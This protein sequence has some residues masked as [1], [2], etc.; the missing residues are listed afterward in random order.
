MST[1]TKKDYIKIR[2]PCKS[3][4]T[5]L[6]AFGRGKNKEF[7]CKAKNAKLM[8]EGHPDWYQIPDCPK[9]KKPT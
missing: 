5:G 9:L 8:G 3:C 2:E 7:Y 6:L 1:I 4:N